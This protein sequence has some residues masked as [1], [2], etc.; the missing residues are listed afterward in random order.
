MNNSASQSSSGSE[1]ATN[2][3]VIVTGASGNIGANLCQALS[4]NYTTIGLDV[5]ACEDADD[6][7]ECDLTSLASIEL[8]LHKIREKHGEQIAAVFN[9][10][11]YFDFTGKSH[12]LYDQLNVQGTAALLDALQSFHV[13][14]FIYAS[15]MLVHQAAEPGIKIDESTPIDPQWAYPE[16]K[17]KAEEAVKAHCKDIPYSIIRLAGLYDD[18]SAVPTLSYQIARIYEKDFKSHVYAGD[19]MAGQAFIHRDDMLDLFTQALDKRNELP[20]QHEILAGEE[21]VMGYRALQNRIGQLVFGEQ[22]WDTFTVPEQLA[23][24][25]AWVQEK[26]EPIIPDAI[27]Y[28]EKPFIRPFM[29]D[30]ASQHYHLDISKAK[31]ELSWA[32]KYSIYDK[33]A[34]IIAALKA[35]PSHWYQV[36]GITRPDWIQT[37]AEKNEQPHELRKKHEK[38]FRQQHRQFLWAHFINMGLG[39]WLLCAPFLMGYESQ[40]MQWSNIGS[41]VAVL[42]FSYIALSWRHSWARWAT[43][44]MGLWLLAAP[45]V[46]WAPTAAAYLNDTLVG[47]LVIGFAVCSRPTPG[48]SCVAAETGPTVPP[49][50]EFNPSGWLQR[51]PII[52]LAFVGFFIS[53]YLCAYQLGHIDAVWDP[54][55]GGSAS[56]PQNG[57]E[58]IITS[59]FSKAW[60]VPD[61]G[62]GAMTYALEIIT[63]L[64]GSVRRWRTMPWLVMLFGIM[65]VPLGAVSIFF[66]I[67]QPILLGTWCTLCL[68][69]AA[70]MLIQIPYSLD[71]L[72]AT[73]EFLY[74]RKKQGRPLLRIFFMGDT[75]KGQ[76]DNKKDNFERPA[77]TIIKDMLGGGVTLPWNLAVC[78]PIGIWLMFTRV[79]LGADGGMANADHLIGA[80]A[81]TVVITALAESGRTVRYALIPLGA[82]LFVTPFVYDASVA[83]IISSV[84]CGAALIA[85]S[86]PKGTIHNSYGL[87]DKTIV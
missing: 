6:S 73:S 44:A 41:G 69:A 65:I 22:T 18:E 14:R 47:M 74:R 24:A 34:D 77:S 4:P 9:L 87:W 37:A 50:W 42:L 30:L 25:G 60:P 39:L 86:F 23:K 2:P 64:M 11:A 59:A 35:D 27:D 58:E 83:A 45:L 76:W 56:D 62:L 1:E 80:L 40:A 53:R 79:T 10:A 20:Q 21:S 48:V 57:T 72:I 82:A 7:Y 16:S 84:L 67:I 61:A 12:P 68:I 43:G 31:A 13:D 33:L 5:E 32:P 15:T 38:I 52:I 70:A 26:S 3:I 19:L 71:E 75:D 63:G 78:I 17:A 36:N 49:G 46:F 29:I 66:I 85:L 8:I 54:F 51:M 28:G 55:F 81:I